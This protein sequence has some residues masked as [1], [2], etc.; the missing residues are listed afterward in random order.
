[1]FIT[2]EK[3]KVT[4][5]LF[6]RGNRDSM[7]CASYLIVGCAAIPF[8]YCAVYIYFYAKMY[9]FAQEYNTFVYRYAEDLIPLLTDGSQSTVNPYD[10]CIDAP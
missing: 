9:A 6:E 10:R 5:E 8:V 7:K 2:R 1:M 4:R 3:L